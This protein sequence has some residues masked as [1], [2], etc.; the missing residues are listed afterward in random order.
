MGN[1]G[2]VHLGVLW[3]VLIGLVLGSVL[4]WPK[5]SERYSWRVRVHLLVPFSRKWTHE[6]AREQILLFR[7]FR[8]NLAI[9]WF[10]IVAIVAAV[11]VFEKLRAAAMIEAAEREFERSD[12]MGNRRSHRVDG[13]LAG[14]GGLK[15]R[16]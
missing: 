7:R 6:V 1:L 10:L 14:T 15:T 3:A 12:A 16:P 11:T 9:I 8:R 2:A 5:E 13:G 4:V